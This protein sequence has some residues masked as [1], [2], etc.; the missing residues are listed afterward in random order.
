[1]R[2]RGLYVATGLA[3]LLASR[4][5]YGAS[6][7]HGEEGIPFNLVFAG[8]NFF[9][10][11]GLLTYFLRKPVRDFFASRSTLI[12]TTL[13]QAKDLK[14]NAEQKY[15]EYDERMKTVE[16]E[17]QRLIQELKKGGELE[18]QRL[19]T[20]A[21]EQ[22]ETLKATTERMM[23]QEIRKAKE[24]LKNEAATLAVDLAEKL[25]RENITAQDQNRL[26]DEYLGKIGRLS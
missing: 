8:I 19:L 1:M 15:S 23:A 24:E 10:L 13:D 4:P 26:V 7:A 18:K 11:V 6:E 16:G 20:L 14:D 2:A 25:L 3:A 12:R 21:K 22:V 5:L 9:I 17:M